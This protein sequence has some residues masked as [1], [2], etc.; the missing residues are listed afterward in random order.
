MRPGGALAEW[1][2]MGLQNPVHRFDS[3]RRLLARLPGILLDEWD[4]GL[5]ARRLVLRSTPPETAD[6]WRSLARNWR[7]P[8]RA[9][10][11]KWG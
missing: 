1:L 2:G 9:T 10:M 8:R 7:A 5:T 3:G 4:P 11:A 6:F